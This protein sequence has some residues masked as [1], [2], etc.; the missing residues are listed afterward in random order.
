M[1]FSMTVKHKSLDQHFREEERNHEEEQQRQ[2]DHEEGRVRGLEECLKELAFTLSAR[3]LSAILNSDAFQCH[4]QV[5]ISQGL[6]FPNFSARIPYFDFA[7]R[8]GFGPVKIPCNDRKRADGTDTRE[9]ADV[10]GGDNMGDADAIEEGEGAEE[11][12]EGEGAAEE[13]ERADE[14]DFQQHPT[15]LN[16]A[17]KISGWLKSLVSHYRSKEILER[18]CTKFPNANSPVE[19]SLITLRGKQRTVSSWENHESNNHKCDSSKSDDVT[20]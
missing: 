9:D 18:H 10:G 5:L 7:E 4:L 3:L 11:E 19:V 12:G 15:T 14:E 16:I 13:L 8:Y 2:L 17:P 20:T 6:T 1:M